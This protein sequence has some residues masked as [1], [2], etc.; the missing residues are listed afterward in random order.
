VA[1][2]RKSD[3]IQTLIDLE[4]GKFGLVIQQHQTQ[5]CVAFHL[6]E[7]PIDGI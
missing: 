3:Q 7:Q 5:P 6:I 1:N 2:F 4:R